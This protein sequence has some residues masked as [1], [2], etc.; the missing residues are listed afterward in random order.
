MERLRDSFVHNVIVH[1]LLFVRDVAERTGYL[2][3]AVLLSRVHDEHAERWTAGWQHEFPPPPQQPWTPEAEAMVYRGRPAM[4]PPAEGAPLAGSLD[5]RM[6][7]ARA[8]S[9]GGQH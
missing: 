4:P 3:L 7:Q 2:G 9:P 5:D 1:P 6:R 8:R